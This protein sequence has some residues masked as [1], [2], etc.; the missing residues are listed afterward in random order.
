MKGSKSL[1]V[2]RRKF[3][4]S[5]LGALAGFSLLSGG[6]FPH[7][8]DTA[9]V[10]TMGKWPY[11]PLDPIATGQSAWEPH[12]CEGCGG[13]SFGA[14][15][16][17]LRSALGTRSPWDRIP[18]NMGMFGNGGG[19]FSQ[20]CGAVIGPYLI[21]NMVGAG[22]TLGKQFYQWY[23]EFP[24]PS[25]NWDNYV[26]KAGSMPS[27]NLIR[28]VSN[29]TLCSDSRGKCEEEYNRLYGEEAKKLTH[30]RCTKL[31]CD[32][33]SKAVE[34]LNEWKAGKIVPPDNEGPGGGISPSGGPQTGG[35]PS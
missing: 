9:Y 23:C 17:G 21:M 30:E 14:I 20:T 27:K 33:T 12:G 7:Y 5:G 8:D 32:C 19:P 4:T 1:A 11:I 22:R 16:Y 6:C 29:S 10:P 25:T 3:I 35:P 28:T 31:I 26:P 13:K 15:V 34:M 18:V 2:T 24:F